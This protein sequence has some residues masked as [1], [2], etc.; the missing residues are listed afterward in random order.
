L[1]C[2]VLVRNTSIIMKTILANFVLYLVF[3]KKVVNIARFGI[4]K[5][6]LTKFGFELIA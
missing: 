6:V 1:R 2:K 5:K 4:L 3:N